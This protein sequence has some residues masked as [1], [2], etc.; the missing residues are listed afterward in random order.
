MIAGFVYPSPHP[1]DQHF[2]FPQINGLSYTL[3]FITHIRA[4]YL[5]SLYIH[6][7]YSVD[8]IHNPD[9]ILIP[10][11]IE[12]TSNHKGP[13]PPLVMEGPPPLTFVNSRP[14]L[15]FSDKTL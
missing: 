13:P 6:C 3:L 5:F 14:L 8:Q 15:F 9:E 11:L 2:L 10:L 1:E 12:L 7:L 4:E